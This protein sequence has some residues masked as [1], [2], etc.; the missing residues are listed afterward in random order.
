MLMMRS[1]RF[2]FAI[3]VKTAKGLGLDDLKIAESKTMSAP[4]EIPASEGP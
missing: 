1:S 4:S 3:S 2:K